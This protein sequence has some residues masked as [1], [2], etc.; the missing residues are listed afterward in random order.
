M[1]YL[2]EAMGRSALHMTSK[3]FSR[4]TALAAMLIAVLLALLVL[5]SLHMGLASSA[6]AG[7]PVRTVNAERKGHSAEG[8]ASLPLSFQP[9]TGTA[10]SGVDYLTHTQGAAIDLSY[11]GA[12]A[13]L[14]GSKDGEVVGLRMIGARRVDPIARERLPGVVNDMRGNDPSQ[15]KTGIPTFERVRYPYLYS[16]ISLDWYGN[17]RQLEYDFHVAPGANPDQIGIRVAG[18]DAV[19]IADNGDLVIRSGDRTM[20]Q[21]APVAYQPGDG[22]DSEREPVAVSFALKEHVL[23]FKLDAYDEHRPLVIDPLILGY[24]TYLGGLGSDAG[25]AIAVASTGSAYITGWTTSEDFDTLNA[26]DPTGGDPRDAFVS[27]LSA[28]GSFLVWS[29]YLGG[30]GAEF[31]NAI[32]VDS[33]GAAYVAGNTNSA[34]FSTANPIQETLAGGRDAFVIKLTRTGDALVYSTY[35]G[36]SYPFAEEG[37]ENAR[38]IAVDST[39]AA[40]VVGGTTSTD[41][42]TVG[43]IEGDSAGEDAFIAK[44]TPSGEELAYSTYLGGDG[45]DSA[46]DVAVNGS[47][48]AFVTGGTSS[49]DFDVVNPFEGDSGG[50]DVFVSRLTPAGDALAYSTYLGGSGDEAGAAIVLDRVGLTYITGTTSSSDYDTAAAQWGDS[51]GEDAFVSR[52]DTFANS[53][54]YSTYLG[55][56]GDDYGSGIAVA[57][58][59]I[60]VAGYTRSSDFPSVGALDAYSGNGDAFVTRLSQFG[61]GVEYSTFLGGSSSDLAADIAVDS[62][63]AAYI[64]GRTYSNDFETSQPIEGSS[65]VT[66]CQGS[67]DVFISRLALD[68]DEVLARR[69]QPILRFD[70][71]ER[72]RP[73]DIAQ[74]LSE[75]THY[76]CEHKCS[77]L[78]S[79]SQLAEYPSEKAYIDIGAPG[80]PGPPPRYSDPDYYYSPVCPPDGVVVDCESGPRSAIY[81]DATKVSPSGYRYIQYWIFYRF[82]DYPIDEPPF[83]DSQDH[84]ADWEQMAFAIPDATALTAPTFDFANFGQHGNNYTYLRENLTCDADSDCGPMAKHVHG[85][86]SG[87]DHATY[88][89]PCSGIIPCFESNSIIPETDHGGEVPWANNGDASALRRLPE[90][91]EGTWKKGPHAWVDWPGFW[92]LDAQLTADRVRSPA[93]QSFYDYPWEAECVDSGCESQ[94]SPLGDTQL[95]GQASAEP[96][97]RCGQWFGSGIAAASC[98][99]AVLGETLDAAEVGARLGSVNLTLV[100]RDGRMV[101]AAT[102]RGLA[103]LAAEPLRPGDRLLLRGRSN[104][105]GILSVRSLTHNV[106]TIARFSEGQVSEANEVI[107]ERHGDRAIPMLAGD[108]NRT[109]APN[110]L[111]VHQLNGT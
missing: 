25:Q 15:W 60:F 103:Q 17:Q 110:S 61:G 84:E 77:Q 88:A 3:R 9:N 20:R 108:G 18:A 85:F 111:M 31:G 48:A 66:C 82:N 83:L 58:S 13:R 16:G 104:Q 1:T 57:G 59:S 27:K 93:N 80:D 2:I 49:A 62:L 72:W 73:L 87:G 24:S 94:L 38:G 47:G 19:R 34:D 51:P 35:L 37:E 95:Q 45:A 92:G 5:T 46:A 43:A 33:N 75:E 29:T 79:L 101:E 4:T 96:S 41:F 107:V 71:G 22:V 30:S 74:M 21:R 42:P 97:D 23:R 10:A 64:V 32:A 40:Y 36:G 99:A 67:P 81:Y 54:G 44:L 98:D 50:Q 12:V 53:L 65:E 14:S 78:T 90:P 76:V 26:L 6:S 89:E 63:G 7:N 11:K 52:L 109:G 39:G 55:G 105:R 106:V 69:F 8:Y 91:Y 56:S 86:V 102:T 28:D 68:S 70:E 100:R